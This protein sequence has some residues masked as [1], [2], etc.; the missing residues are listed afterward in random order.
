MKRISII[1]RTKNEEFWIGRCLNAIISQAGN[2]EIEVVLV[3]NCSTDKTLEKAKRIV[4]N[5]IIESITDYNP[6]VSLNMGVLK[7]TGNY[8]VCISAHCIPENEYWLSELIEPLKDAQI[9]AS[10]GRQIP[11]PTSNPNDKRDLWLTFG[12]DDVVQKKDPFIHNAN[13]AYRREDLLKSP[14]DESLTNIEDRSWG[15]DRIQEGKYIYYASSAV[16]YHEHGI[17]QTG[18]LDRLLGVIS[19]MDVIHNRQYDFPY[20]YGRP[21]R[22]AAPKRALFLLLS[23]RYGTSDIN[24]F[25]NKY[26]SIIKNFQG[27]DIYCFPTS[28]NILMEIKGYSEI[29]TKRNRIERSKYGSALMENLSLIYDDLFDESKFYDYVSYFDIREEVP[30]KE[31]VNSAIDSLMYERKDWA[32]GYEES[33]VSAHADTNS[34]LHIVAK[35]GWRNYFRNENINSVI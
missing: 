13:A 22:F 27:W 35:T 12:L 8:C 9:C 10:Y 16:V 31:K 25:K 4:P 14:F 2:Y 24:N 28:E 26:D 29:I 7:S 19:M 23:E 17:H 20:Y 30:D 1:I 3:D 5:A 15:Q 33:F 32:F 6:S 34:T 18:N 21:E 11:L